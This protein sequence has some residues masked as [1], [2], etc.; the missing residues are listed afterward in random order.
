[1]TKVKIAQLVCTLPPYKGG[2]G[3]SAL[4]F[5]ELLQEEGAAVVNFTPNFRSLKT[6]TE[7]I[8]KNG[9]EMEICFLSSLVKYGNAAFPPKL[10]PL[11][12]KYDIVYLH[13][14]FFGGAE[15]AWLAKNIFRKKFKLAVHYHM[16]VRGLSFFA[17][18]FRLPSLLTFNSLFKKA[19]TITCASLDYIAHSDLKKIYQKYPAKFLEIPFGV[20][21]TKFF[22]KKGKGSNRITILFVGGL[23]KAHYFKGVE[24]LIKAAALLKKQKN[25][26]SWRIHIVGEG[27]LKKYYQNKAQT[28]GLEEYIK[29]KGGMEESELIQEY[30]ASDIFV[31]PSIN[32]G[33]A[34]GMVLLEAMACQTP[35][36]AS[37]LPGVRSVFEDGEQGYTTKPKNG[38][39]LAE[40]IRSL[41][42]SPAKRQKMGDNALKLVKEKYELEKVG[43]KLREMIERI[44]KG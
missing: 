13:Y 39:D 16:D 24:Y 26:L 25:D 44:E 12:P 17:K 31:L 34:F 36:I 7:V 29:F 6:E 11:L 33:E 43:E 15:I 9:T 1:M 32:K 27:E 2:I 41:I 37:D 35:V 38:S 22:P 28:A 19:E 21:T 5:A 40:K 3:N 10:F 4:Q 20:D 8:K 42:D 18:I 30:Q 14:P 23:D